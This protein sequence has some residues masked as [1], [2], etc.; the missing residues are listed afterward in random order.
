ML[1]AEV[2]SARAHSSS[3]NLNLKDIFIHLL[4]VFDKAEL[5]FGRYVSSSV[6]FKELM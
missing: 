5:N 2:I 6:L 4:P 1:L 3:E